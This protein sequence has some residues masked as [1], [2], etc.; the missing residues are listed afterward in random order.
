M[1]VIVLEEEFPL[2]RDELIASLR[3]NGIGS[4][5][6]FCPMNA[7]PFLRRQAG[8]RETACPVAESLWERGMYL[9]STLTLSQDEVAEIVD[10]VRAPVL[11]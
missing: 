3:S 6:H 7:Q 8:F 4:R 2:S 10:Q 9:P 5:T 1:Y 11:A